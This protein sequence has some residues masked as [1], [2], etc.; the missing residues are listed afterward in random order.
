MYMRTPEGVN[1]MNDEKNMTECRSCKAHMAD[2]LLDD[3]YAAANPAMAAHA[4]EC[5][6]CSVELAGL[7]ST[8]ALLDDWSAP[9]PSA[10]FD[11][12]LHARLREEVAAAPEGIWERVRSFFLFSTGRSLRPVMAGALALV[13][14]A[15]GGSIFLGVHQAPTVAASPTVNDLKILDNNAQ[16]LQQMDQLL[17]TSGDDNGAPPTT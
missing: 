11:T 16:A 9:E 15:G 2:L 5:A 4:A 10:F 1:D 7:R 6:E 17:D 13:M 12:K 8:F 14:V 3:A